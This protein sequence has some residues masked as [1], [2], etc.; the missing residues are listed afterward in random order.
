MVV[1]IEDAAQPL[2]SADVEP[3]DLG[4]VGDGLWQWSLWSG[5]GDALVRSVV[6]VEL[7]VFVECV[8]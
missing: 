6:V 3:G 7:L 4:W 2:A 1:L 5:V 8:E